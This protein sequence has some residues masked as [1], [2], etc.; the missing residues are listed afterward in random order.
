MIIKIKK[1]GIQMLYYLNIVDV[2]PG[3]MAEY[4]EIV[5]KEMIPMYNKVGLKLM[6]SWHAS[7]GSAN[8]VYAMFTFNDYTDYQK[9]TQNARQ[10]KDYLKAFA[11]LNTVITSQRREFLEPNAWSQMK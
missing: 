8:R 11:R 6:A 1:D 9:I 2:A 5:T 7:S 4:G 10:D 3:K